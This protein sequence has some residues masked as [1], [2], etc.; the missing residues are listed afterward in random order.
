V[1]FVYLLAAKPTP[2]VK[3]S[4][5]FI[6]LNVHLNILLYS[7]NIKL[8]YTCGFGRLDRLSLCRCL[9]AEVNRHDIVVG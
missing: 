9:M 7:L 2:I 3:L 8:I 5:I 1:L 4:I 6:H